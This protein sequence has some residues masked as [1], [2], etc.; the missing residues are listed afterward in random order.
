MEKTFQTLRQKL[1]PYAK[2]KKW[3]KVFCIGTH[4]TGTTTLNLIFYLIGFDCAPQHEIEISTTEQVQYGI[5]RELFNKVNAYDF[6]QDSPFAEGSTYVALDAYFP[7]SKFILTYRDPENWFD[8]MIKFDQRNLNTKN[9]NQSDIENYGY[10]RED[11]MI[12]HKEY[13]YLSEIDEKNN[14]NVKYNWNLLYDKN[15]YIDIYIKRRDEIVKYFQRRPQD[16]LIIDL[17]KEKD[18]KKIT[19]F[20]DLPDFINFSVPR[21]N[22]TDGNNDQK[23]IQIFNSKLSDMVKDRS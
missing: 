17:T 22:S 9:I 2:Q 18:I 20:L 8:S 7:Q 3:N 13:I 15:H 1:R 4:K 14:F 12:K 21:L 10:L 19:D 23:S 11:Y 6:F 16:L 5:Y